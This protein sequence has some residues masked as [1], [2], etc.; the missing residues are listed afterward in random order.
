MEG[1]D[2]TLGEI[3]GVPEW[4]ARPA[5]ELTGGRP[6]AT[7]ADV[8][9]AVA[10]LPGVAN[11]SNRPV[12]LELGDTEDVIAN[13]VK[14][15]TGRPLGGQPM[16]LRFIH[17]ARN[18]GLVLVV[19]APHPCGEADLIVVGEPG[20]LNRSIIRDVCR[21]AFWGVG[22]WRLVARIPADRPDLQDLARRGGFRFEGTARRF[23]GGIADAQVWAMTGEECPW[24]PHQ[25][26]VIPPDTFP[27]SSEQVH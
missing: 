12:R 18:R 4:T 7:Q 21:W 26:P 1:D 23:F 16:W 8:A 2:R 13:W 9:A 3:L 5:G 27:R 10:E 25:P 11:L 6:D 15:G 20:V 19:N 22:L 14:I 24:L 17:V